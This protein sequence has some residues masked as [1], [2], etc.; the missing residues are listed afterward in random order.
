MLTVSVEGV[1]WHFCLQHHL[2]PVL[3]LD[4]TSHKKKKK[5]IPHYN[6]EKTKL[7]GHISDVI[8]KS[9]DLEHFLNLRP[10]QGLFFDHVCRSNGFQS[11]TELGELWSLKR[12]KKKTLPQ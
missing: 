11:F 12:K 8:L 5:T 3:A 4:M 10:S 9:T 6:L 2:M 1:P 7:S